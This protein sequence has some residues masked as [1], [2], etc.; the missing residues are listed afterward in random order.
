MTGAPSACQ[1]P[2]RVMPERFNGARV[3]VIGASS[4]LGLATAAAFSREGAHVVMASRGGSKLAGAVA[5][6]GSGATALTLDTA[7]QPSIAAAFDQPPFDHVV[8][9]SS[10]APTGSVRELSLEDAYRAMDSKFWGAYRIARAAHIESG[11]S[12]TLVS[13]Q[14]SVR[15]SRTAVVQGAINAAIEGLA[16]GLALELAP[17]R[18]N[19]VSPG[20]IDTPLFGH[21]EADSRR[22]LF[23]DVAGRL[24]VGRVGDA[25]NIASAIL[26]L[27]ANPFTTGSVLQVDGGAAIS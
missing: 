24:P 26:F 21:L 16:R 11:G 6:V 10:E 22:L 18:V 2:K 14:L 12:L 15:P 5:Q 23:A 7:D 13:G 9:T 8:V 19:V 27:A 17:I 4:G 25:D 3:I 20:T 1:G